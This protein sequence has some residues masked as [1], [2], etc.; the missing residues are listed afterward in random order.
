M[1]SN[2]IDDDFVL[3][4]LLCQLHKLERVCQGGC[5]GRGV[6]DVIERRCMLFRLYVKMNVFVGE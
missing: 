6:M 3:S 1:G 4:F 2:V 5:D